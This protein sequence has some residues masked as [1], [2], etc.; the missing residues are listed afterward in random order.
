MPCADAA[1]FVGENLPIASSPPSSWGLPACAIEPNYRKTYYEPAQ[2][3]DRT[4]P[5]YAYVYYVPSGFSPYEG[6]AAAFTHAGGVLIQVGIGL[7]ELALPPVSAEV[8]AL[9]QRVGAHTDI[10]GNPAWVA[11]TPTDPNGGVL[12]LWWMTDQLGRRVELHLIGPYSTDTLVGVARSLTAAI[13]AH[14]YAPPPLPTPSPPG[15]G[16]SSS[17]LCTTTTSASGRGCPG[18]SCARDLP[19]NMPGGT[20]PGPQ[21][22]PPGAT[23][24]STASTT[25]SPASTTT[26][27]TAPNA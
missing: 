6:N 25:S 27:T 1:K 4:K 19:P 22:G 2:L 16:A 15:C 23:T 14:E 10:N 11:G 3:P 17:P 24:T 21:Y 7:R 12:V 5:Y 13:P 18:P 8:N 20:V 9:G 26:T